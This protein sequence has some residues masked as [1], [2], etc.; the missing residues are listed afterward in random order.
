MKSFVSLLFIAVSITVFFVVIKPKYNEL[1]NARDNV[2][3][4]HANLETA[5]ELIKSRNELLAKYQSIPKKD[6]DNLKV[7]LP[8]SVDNI[9]LIIQVNSFA[10]KNGLTLLRNVEYQVDQEKVNTN[11]AVNNMPY[12]E[13]NISFQTSGQYKNF[14]SFI[15]DLEQNLRLVDITKVEFLPTDQSSQGSGS[16]MTFKVA[17]KTYWLKQ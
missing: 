10:T 11:T 5:G 8:D 6:L 14:L 16:G 12:G 3:K 7:L 17:L 1:Q 13:F 4:A 2:K 9:R 15:S